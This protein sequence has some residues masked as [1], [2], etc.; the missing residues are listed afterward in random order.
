[1]TKYMI[2][3]NGKKLGRVASEA[4]GILLGKKTVALKPERV[5]DVAVEIQNASKVDLGVK[6]LADKKYLRYSGFP[7]GLKEISLEQMVEKRGFGEVF[8]MAVKRMLPNNKLRVPR[9]KRL[10]I[11]D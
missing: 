1:M 4:A 8:R 3:A 11:K 2:D 6:K 9:M 10:V 7:G 5:A